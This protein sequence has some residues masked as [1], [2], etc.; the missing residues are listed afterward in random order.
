MFNTTAPDYPASVIG[1]F[2]RISTVRL[3][4]FSGMQ[5]TNGPY[6]AISEPGP[7]DGTT[8]A[9]ADKEIP[10]SE[11]ISA[12]AWVLKHQTEIRKDFFAPFV[13]EYEEMRDIL[14]CDLGDEKAA[15][16]VPKISSPE[17]LSPLCGLVALHIRG[18][19]D[20]GEA[21]FGIELGCNWED[22]HGAGVRFNGLQIEEAGHADVSFLFCS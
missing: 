5:I 16:L 9:S 3:D 21:R 2:H 8:H 14:I 15:K 7:S 6:G 22:E 11:F 12:I 19:N 13:D 1:Q 4:A 10:E 17:D 20:T 18:L